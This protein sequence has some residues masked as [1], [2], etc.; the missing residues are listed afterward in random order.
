MAD[1]HHLG[2]RQRRLFTG[3]H[4]AYVQSV[5]SD[6]TVSLEEYNWGND[7]SYHTRTIP[8]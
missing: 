8:A 3:N 5:N 4:V 7:H 2:P 1:Q 6:G